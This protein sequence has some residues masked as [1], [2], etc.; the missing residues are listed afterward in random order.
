VKVLVVYPYL[1]DQSVAGHSVMYET[2]LGLSTMGHQITVVSGEGGYMQGP[3][4][5]RR[6]WW[7]RL[8]W[9][10]QVGPVRVLRTLSYRGHQRGMAGRLLSY[11]LLSLL[12]PVAV[13]LAGRQDVALLSPPPLYPIFT[14]LLACMLRRLPAVTEVRDLWPGSIVQMGLMRNRWLIALTA[15]MERFTYNHSR[16]IVALTEG[17]RDDVVGRG[18]PADRVH[19]LACAVDTRCLRP[20]PQWRAEVRARHHWEAQWV[21]LYFGALGEANNLPVMLRVAQRLQ[22]TPGI[23]IALAGDGFRRDWL[24]AEVERLGL[25]NVEVLPAVPK[26]QAAGYLNAADASLVT[27][28]DLQV[29]EGAIPTKLVESLAC[30]RP[31]LCGVRGEAARTVTRS[32]AGLCFAPDDD[33]ALAE[34]MLMLKS[35]PESALA[36]GT[37]GR[38]YA[39]QYFDSAGRAQRMAGLLK[40]AAG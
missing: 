4:A 38:S 1:V 34:A 25:N 5:A 31:V 20:D 30:G 40:Q 36:M 23:R 16:Q 28:Q 24:M 18:W 19:T 15:W 26:D 10:E 12:N 9:T 7:R 29:F 2:L 37:A 8:V 13:L 6:P 27:L 35:N 17:I 22:G 3:A 11:A 32:G 39:Q 21:A 33:A 14:S